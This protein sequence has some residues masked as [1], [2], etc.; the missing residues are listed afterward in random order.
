M[1]SYSLPLFYL[2]LD[3]TYTKTMFK[4]GME[5]GGGGDGGVDGG[6]S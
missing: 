3:Q 6:G 4:G 5:G 1:R 2:V